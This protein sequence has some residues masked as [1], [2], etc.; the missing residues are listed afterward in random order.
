MK[1]ILDNINK[2]KDLKILSIE[3]MGELAKEMRSAIINRVSNI[4][5]HVGPNLGIVEATIAM[6]YVFNSPIDKI[7]YDV[8]HQCYPH[9]LLTGR[10]DGFLN[11]ESFYKISGYTN[12]D[13]S[14]HDIFKI[15]HTSTSISLACGLAKARDL[16]NTN[17]NI[18]AVIGDGSLS[19]GEAYEGLNNVAELN[20]NMI[21]V[22]NDNDMSISQNYG[23]LYQNL[24]LLRDTQGKAECNFFKSLGLDYCYVKKGNNITELVQVFENVKDIDHPI[25][26]HINT[27][28]GKGLYYAEQNKEI[29]H[30]NMPFEIETGKNKFTLNSNDITYQSIT[31]DYLKIK[32]KKDENLVVITPAIPG[33][34]GF[35]P[36]FRKELGKRFIDVG[37]AEEHAI[38]FSSGLARSGMKPVIGMHSSFIQRTYD[39]LSQDLAIN[40]NSAVILVF[41]NGITSMDVTHLGTFDIPLISNIP[42]I[43]YLAPTCVQEYIAMLDWGIEQNKYPVI[44]RVPNEEPIERDINIQKDYSV[45]NKY[46]VEKKGEDIAIIALGSFFTL[47][48]KLEKELK[49][50]KDINATLINPRYITGIDIEL[51]EKLKLKHN[52]IITLEDGELDGGF[53]EKITRFYGNSSMKVLN[54]GANK[55]FTDRKSLQE[56]YK[57]YHL[58]TNQIIEDIER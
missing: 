27:V 9:K 19:G 6:H 11:K 51:L 29:W 38:A 57:N 24:K 42:N 47:G 5:G 7:V 45:L 56:L 32:S 1:K 20:T 31:A 10:K 55:E 28:K 25:V 54:Y 53:G 48:Q 36:E 46:K 26:V 23:G 58:T 12:P 15:G 34:C 33:V 43:V 21:I 49:D 39:Q 35:T 40:N 44:I 18:I 14:E 52:M 8:S 13:E 22:V 37:I 16:K 3:E 17:E 2:P 30:W 50:K 41:G 4:G